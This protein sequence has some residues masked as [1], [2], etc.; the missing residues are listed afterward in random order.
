MDGR[1][2]RACPHL[3]RLL[4]R[5]SKTP[6]APFGAISP[7]PSR[8]PPA[9]PL[10]LPSIVD[11]PL[12]SG[13][14]AVDPPRKVNKKAAKAPR[15]PRSECTPEEIA[16][17]DA[18][19]AKRRGRRA[20]VKVNAAE[21]DAREGTRRKAEVDEKEDIVNKAYALLMLGMGR[22]AGFPAAA[23]GPAST[24]SS[25]ARPPHCQSPTSRTAPMLPGFPPLRHDAQTRFSGSPDVGRSST[26]ALSSR[27]NTVNFKGREARR[28]PSSP[29]V[30]MA[31]R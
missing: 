30:G 24:G 4:V 17:L 20:V 8:L 11:A 22:P 18:E 1:D 13:G 16:K 23:V 2:A 26:I 28:R 3:A 25:A 21:R 15:K 7:K 5:E 12:N 6:H 27:I 14:L 19:S 10:S 9:A 29:E 31:R